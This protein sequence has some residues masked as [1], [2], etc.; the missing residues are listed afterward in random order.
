MKITKLELTPDNDSLRYT[1]GIDHLF[2][3][4]E[5]QLK[6]HMRTSKTP[7]TYTLEITCKASS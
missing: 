2:R 6:E 5:A 7:Q 1:R 3:T 4:A